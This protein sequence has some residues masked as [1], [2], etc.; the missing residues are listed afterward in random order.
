MCDH[1]ISK[2]RTRRFCRSLLNL[3]SMTSSAYSYVHK[4]HATPVLRMQKKCPRIVS[5]ELVRYP[6]TLPSLKRNPP[7]PFGSEQQCIVT[8]TVVTRHYAVHCHIAPHDA[9]DCSQATS[10]YEQVERSRCDPAAAVGDLAI[11]HGHTG[12]RGLVE[13]QRGETSI[14]GPS[15]T[16]SINQ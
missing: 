1:E 12:G 2:Y 3:P 14:T 13:T 8:L 5:F 11:G 16:G 7:T 6:L 10:D 9:P 15:D 4:Q